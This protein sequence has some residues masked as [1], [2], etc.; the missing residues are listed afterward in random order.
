MLDISSLDTIQE[1]LPQGAPKGAAQTLTLPIKGMTCA[2]CST[3]LER[4]LSKVPGVVKSQVNLAS[5]Q[6]HIDLDS[7]ATSSEKIYRAIVKA[8]FT[9]PMEELEFRIGG[10]TCAACSVR[11]EKILGRL[12]GVSKI[13]V[14]LAT[15][16]AVVKA[17]SGVLNPNRIIAAIQRA[18]FTAKPLLDLAGR[19]S[20][21]KA[22]A[23]AQQRGEQRRL[24]L[25]ALFTLPLALPMLLM[26]FGIHADLPAEIQL[27]LATPVQFWI[28][29]RFYVGAYKSLRGG[30]GNMDVLVALGTSAA[31]GLS[32]WNT[33]VPGTGNYLYFE[34]SAMVITLVLLGKWLEGRAKRSA[35]SAIHALMALRPTKAR[36]EQAGKIVEVP[37]EQVTTGHVVL[38]RPGERMPVDGVIIEGSSQL[39]ESLITGESLPVTRKKGESV[40]GGSVNGEGLLRIRATTVGV[41][42]TLARIIHLVE[43]AQASK[44]PVQKL[45][46]Q[47]THVFVP[48]VVTIAFLA[49]TGWWLLDG[50]T[51]I[52]FTAAIAVL[53]IACPCALGLATPTALMVGT[54]IA[55]RHGILIRDAIALERAQNSDTVVFDKTGTLTEGQPAV[56]VV[57][58][59]KGSPEELLQLVASAQQGS[60]H[61]LAKAVL[62]KAQGLPLSSPRNFRS[63]PG[64][65]LSAQVQEQ[66]ILVGNRRL[67][68]ENQLVLSPL[69]AQAETL[70]KSGHTVIWIAEVSPTPGLLGILAVTD[71]IK[72]VAPQAVAALQAQGLTTMMLTGDNPGV[73]HV[74]A[75]KVGINQVIAEV[76]PEDKAAQIQALR[77]QGRRVAMI[78][79]GVNDA[80]ALAAA[81]VGMAM[82]TGTDV[83]ME[84]AGI[85]LMRGDPTLVAEALSISRATY[86][87]IRQ[88]LFWALIYN[89]IAIPLAAFGML[90]PVIAGAAMAMSSVSVVS[91]SLLLQ[92]WRP[93]ELG[94]NKLSFISTKL[95]SKQGE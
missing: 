68:Q 10:M 11:L 84:T 12:S 91:N 50:S 27:L 39:D 19:Q 48:I 3:R 56:D 33:L 52:A 76:L 8:G 32:T 22:Q 15:E 38:V 51:E 49:F 40:T 85:T 34:A 42:S 24:L 89:V 35:A 74:V 20:Q 79:D 70:E 95:I 64:L 62:T 1:P 21:E 46:D 18:G 78:G 69:L 43:E 4:V 9:M 55:A 72:S 53:V 60:E 7:Q 29:S 67:M 83:A 28:G 30:T 92:R 71:L 31:W 54:G 93:Q 44:A 36:I 82:G 47:V 87:K 17:P 58:P 23:T 5:E 81:D 63:L 80:P 75:E 94:K 41:E 57:L 13:A 14:N 45:V 25:A 2:T 86:H 77:T 37:A 59:L 26:P 16:R 90:N 6:A 65:G 88:N 61:P 73:A 66:T